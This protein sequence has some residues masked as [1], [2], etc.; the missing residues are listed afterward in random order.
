M[1][2]ACPGELLTLSCTVCSLVLVWDS[3][4]VPSS[5]GL[6]IFSLHNDE[7]NHSVS[8]Q[9]IEAVLTGNNGSC[10]SST[11][12]I[13]PMLTINGTVFFCKDFDAKTV[14]NWTIFIYSKSIDYNNYGSMNLYIQVLPPPSPSPPKTPPLTLSPALP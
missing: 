11:L 9:G 2:V 10:L 14:Q 1:V 8:H 7:V 13:T 6:I 5:D 3:P 12:E 4:V